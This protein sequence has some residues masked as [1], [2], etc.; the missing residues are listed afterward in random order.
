MHSLG[1]YSG[2][3]LRR[4]ARIYA[5][6]NG[7]SACTVVISSPICWEWLRMRKV[8]NPKGFGFYL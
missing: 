3:F 2:G 5:P 7:G 8:K 1:G 4:R 6:L